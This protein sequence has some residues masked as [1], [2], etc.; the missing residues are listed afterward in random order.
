MSS[1]EKYFLTALTFNDIYQS[2][3]QDNKNCI[4]YSKYKPAWYKKV[5][6]KCLDFFIRCWIYFNISKTNDCHIHR[7]Q[8]IM[9]TLTA[10][11]EQTM[12]RTAGHLGHCEHS[13]D[14]WQL[15]AAW[16]SWA[17]DPYK[18]LKMKYLSRIVYGI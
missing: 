16:N 10:S 2:K 4:K 9:L 6:S 7:D 18:A 5:L 11:T 8:R 12:C 15:T 1:W 13:W 14:N 17:F 3:N